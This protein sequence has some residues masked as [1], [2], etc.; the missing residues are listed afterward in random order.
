MLTRRG[1]FAGVAATALAPSRPTPESLANAAKMHYAPP[2]EPGWRYYLEYDGDGFR[3]FKAQT[4]AVERARNACRTGSM[5]RE[6]ALARLEA[7]AF[8]RNAS[9]S[10]C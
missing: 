8:N 7:G 5:S 4:S 1:L 9:E 2:L 10:A 6:E 3:A